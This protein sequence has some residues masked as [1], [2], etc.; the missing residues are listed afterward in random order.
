MP[1]MG[2]QSDGARRVQRT[3]PMPPEKRKQIARKNRALDRA[4]A[5]AAGRTAAAKS[6]KAAKPAKGLGKAMQAE[7]DRNKKR[8]NKPL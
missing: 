8:G 2:K 4:A 3:K 1:G 6:R 5:R 7:Q